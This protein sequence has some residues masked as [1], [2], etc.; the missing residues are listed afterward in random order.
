MQIRKIG[1]ALVGA[2]LTS[3]TLMGGAL[4]ADLGNYPAPF[5]TDDGV[6]STIVVGSQGTDAAGIAKDI[7]GAINIGAALAQIGGT[8]SGGTSATTTVTGAVTDDIAIG[9]AVSSVLTGSPYKDN[10]IAGLLD[11]R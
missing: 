8:V 3:A 1:T 7:V 4:A 6:Q 10:K 5:A 9:A 11:K 2:V